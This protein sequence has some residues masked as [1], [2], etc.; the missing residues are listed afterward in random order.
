M[1]T[2]N[3]DSIIQKWDLPEENGCVSNNTGGWFDVEHKS[4]PSE[5]DHL[6]QSHFEAFAVSRD[7]MP[8]L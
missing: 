3:A 8:G 2:E 6:P 4:C 7:V 1:F 5:E